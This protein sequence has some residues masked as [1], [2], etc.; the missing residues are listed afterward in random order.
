MIAFMRSGVLTSLLMK[1]HIT[2]SYN[3]KMALMIFSLQPRAPAGLGDFA[4]GARGQL[5]RYPRSSHG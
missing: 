4:L 5:W 3:S 1:V 2:L